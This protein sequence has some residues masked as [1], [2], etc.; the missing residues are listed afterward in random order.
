MDIQE[1]IVASLSK[2]SDRQ[3]ANHLEVVQRLATL[4]TRVNDSPI[5]EIE[6]RVNSLEGW[7]NKVVGFTVAANVIVMG[8]YEWARSHVK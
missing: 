8:A 4:E 3:Q 2:I 1:Q 5:N 7:R 6:D